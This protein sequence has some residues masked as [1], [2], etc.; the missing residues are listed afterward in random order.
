[1]FEEYINAIT[2]K[3]SKTTDLLRKL[4]NRSPQSSLIKIYKSLV[5]PHLDYGGVTFDKTYNNSF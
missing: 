5:G 3:V 2:S 4:N 1:M